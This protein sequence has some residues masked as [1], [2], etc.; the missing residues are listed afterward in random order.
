MPT[1]I[2]LLPPPPPA[3][4]PGAP[5]GDIYIFR[6]AE[7]APS[8]N[9]FASW[10]LLVA[11]AALVGGPKIVYFDNTL[12][13]CVIPPG[14]PVWD[15][16]PGSTTFTGQAGPLTGLT[17]TPVA[18]SDGAKLAG[19]YLFEWIDIDSQTTTFCID[20]PHGTATLYGFDFTARIRQTGAG[21]LF[22][23]ANAGAGTAALAGLRGAASF[24]NAGGR[25]I[26]TTAAGALVGVGTLEG[27]SIGSDTIASVVGSTVIPLLIDP[28]SVLDPTQ[29]GVL[30]GP[31][32]PQLMSLAAKVNYDDTL[33]LPLLGAN[34]VQ[35]AIDALKGGALAGNPNAFGY[36]N[37]AGNALTSSAL[38]TA[39]PVDQFGRP[40]ILDRRQNGPT[41][42]VYRQGAWTSD[43]DPSDIAS[44][45]VVLYGPAP[46][47]LQNSSNGTIGRSKYSRFA[48]RMIQAGV[49]IGY[50]FRVDAEN[51]APIWAVGTTYGAGDPVQYKSTYYTSLAALNLG[52]VP[53]TPPAT[54]P[55]WQATDSAGG[56]YLKDN[57]GAKTFI[58]DRS[59]GDGFFAGK[60][61]V[62]GV[63]DPTA[64][65]LSDP[66]AG[67]DLYIESADGA[68]AAVSPASRGRI[69]YNTATQSWQMS[70]NGGA[71]T[72]ISAMPIYEF[73]FRPSEPSPSGNVFNAWASLVT[74]ASAVRGTKIVYFDRSLAACTIPAG[75]WNFGS[76]TIFCGSNGQ[77]PGTPV[78]IAD[79]ATLV[80]VFEF[81]DLAIDSQTTTFVINALSSPFGH[82]IV[83]RFK[84]STTVT[85]TGGH[86]GA[87]LRSITSGLGLG[88]VCEFYDDTKIIT[89]AAGNAFSVTSPGGIS[90][91]TYDRAEVQSNT[92][93]AAAPGGGVIGFLVSPAASIST[94]QAGI[95]PGG[96]LQVLLLGAAAKISYDD[97][98]VAPPIGATEVQNAIDVLKSAPI[99]SWKFSGTFTGS[100]NPSVFYAGDVPDNVYL[101]PVSYPR[102]SP[103]GHLDFWLNVPA[104]T[105]V[106]TTT[107][108]VYLNGA[109][110][111]ATIAV[112]GG[113]PF[114]GSLSVAV[115]VVQDD[116]IDLRLDCPGVLGDVGNSLRFSASV[117]FRP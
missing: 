33:V 1:A 53:P 94:A 34:Q 117:G 80:N 51:A 85:Q 4:T 87:L 5:G 61:T 104:D 18:I 101:S 114:T 92:I 39:A 81:V 47:G 29:P 71:W 54:S 109:P 19:V 95:L 8:G 38:L 112:P 89:S 116:Q 72:D 100:N 59:T 93:A 30:S 62:A 46:N 25:V 43:G 96:I 22:I 90:F 2:S 78:A 63:V 60:L 91:Y 17:S 24:V 44:E 13:P 107:F 32:V 67:T 42:P 99:E 27:A 36:F 9:V 50:V 84:G 111:A 31:F 79:G 55:W 82:N 113:G 86:G 77:G 48:I 28:A 7:P 20:A 26:G 35:A 58:V 110:T 6:P 16:G 3:P 69:R 68:S 74:A 21:G 15:F 40:Q 23:R 56:M 65:I 37:P 115:V 102:S 64:L 75:A 98:L 106:S 73:V 12:A 105:L 103:S 66:A 41:G 108:T 76:Y 70:A 45:G 52:N 10:P 49:D 11:S 83:Y 97:T 88:T 57:S 14:P